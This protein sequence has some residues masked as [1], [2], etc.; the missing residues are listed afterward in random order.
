VIA[1]LAFEWVFLSEVGAMLS[2]SIV[3]LLMTLLVGLGLGL[4]GGVFII[5]I[6]KRG[7]APAYLHSPLTLAI[8]MAVFVLS[9][10]I[11]LES[12]LL[13]VTV[14]GLILA[15]QNQVKIKHILRFKEDVTLLL[16]SVL[17]IML[18]A[19]I[20][21]Y[22]LVGYTTWNTVLFLVSVVF[23]ARPLGV[24]LCTLGS[25]L[26][27]RH[28]VFMS[29]TAPRGIIAASIGS[30]FALKL[31]NYGVVDA[32]QLVFFTFIVIFVT[33]AQSGLLAGNLAKWLGVTR[34]HFYGVLIAGSNALSRAIAKQLINQKI[35][36]LLVDTNKQSI[37][38]ARMHHIPCVEASILDDSILDELEDRKIGRFLAV[39][40]NDDLN[41]L[42]V[43]KYKTVFGRSKVYRLFPQDVTHQ[44]HLEIPTLFS[45]GMTYTQLVNHMISGYSVAAIKLNDGEELRDILMQYDEPVIP[46]FFV[47][48]HHELYIFSEGNRPPQLPNMTLIALVP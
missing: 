24:F 25:R 45:A 22:D 43:N 21:F 8:V 34:P 36:V 13:S 2:Y 32:E 47:S 29:L 9:N 16:I 11:Q 20:S 44:Q 28:K 37:N 42:A 38:E 10:F 1:V 18:A 39:T 19:R 12:G 30:L 4:A 14:M 6:L 26:T 46:L 33:V 27:W 48:Q 40:P 23:V 7:W 35:D 15:N 31:S 17:F 41:V 3:F 5:M